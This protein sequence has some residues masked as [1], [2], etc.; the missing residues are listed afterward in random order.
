M[1]ELKRFESLAVVADVEKISVEQKES[2]FAKIKWVQHE[3]IG[4]ASIMFENEVDPPVAEK[5]LIDQSL[6]SVRMQKINRK[7]PGYLAPHQKDRFTLVLNGID[8]ETDEKDILNLLKLDL[9]FGE[10]QVKVHRQYKK[11]SDETRN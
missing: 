6:G 5:M 11:Q 2:V 9:F 4:S 7:L 10:P 8:F 1:D 3:S